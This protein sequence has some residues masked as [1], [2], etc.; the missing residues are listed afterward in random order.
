[1]I[2]FFLRTA[3]LAGL[4][5]VALSCEQDAVI[6]TVEITTP[7]PRFVELPTGKV[8]LGKTADGRNYALL[9]AE[10]ITAEDA[11]EAGNVVYFRNVGNKQLAGDFVANLQLDNTPDVSYYI[12]D[13]RPSE[14]LPVEVT[15]A[16]INRSMA[17]WDA[18]TC[19]DLGMY[20][21]PY[22]G[23]P[24][25]FYSA[26]LGFGG[27][28]GYVA[29]IV[30]AGWLPAQFFNFLAPNGSASI[31]GVT[32]TL[33]FTDG[34]G[35]LVD[36]DNNGKYDVAFREIYYNDRFTWSDGPGGIDVETV[37]L[38]EA[39]HGLSQA[40]FGKLFQTVKNNKFHFAPRA[41]MNAGYTGIQR[42]IDATDMGGH[43]SNWAQ[44]PNN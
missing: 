36:T 15:T 27:T 38:H 35:N 3:S 16:A 39:G 41:V 37:S 44:W 12:D 28:F 33:V 2:R 22:D 32:F 19:S 26:L 29:D 21:I 43:C 7:E 9:M 11:D 18:V 1:M 6:E 10:Y 24:T 42:T 40:H 34:N 4:A 31:L 5:L 25:G 13:S 17:T 8:N 23:R 20:E 14:D 30:Q